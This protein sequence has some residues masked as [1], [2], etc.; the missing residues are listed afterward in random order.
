[1]AILHSYHPTPILFQ[2]GLISIHWYALFIVL[3]ILF[4][5][6]IVLRVS[7]HYGL[8]ADDVYDLAFYLI[9]FST[10][11]ARLYM[12]VLFPSFYLSNP[13]E[14]FKVWNGGLAIHGAIL[15]G[16]LTLYLYT[17]KK[18]Q[19]FWFWGDIIVVALALGQAI[20]RWGNYF[21]QEVYGSPTNLPWGI[22]IDFVNRVSGYTQYEYFHPTFLYESI[23]NFVLFFLLL[24]LH[25]LRIKN[26]ERSG[27]GNQESVIRNKKIAGYRLL[28]TDYSRNGIIALIYLIGYS[29]IRIAMEQFRI[30][31]TQMVFGIR[32]PV[33]VS[34]GVIVTAVFI[35]AR[36]AKRKAFF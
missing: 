33:L 34:A 17:K 4:G 20:G 28:V 9:I 25:Y 2:L 26:K 22:P 32:F 21:N 7:K 24:S 13:L 11:G 29:F 5:L 8:K 36:N 23:L 3:G 12:I 19:N 16:V 15:F 27:I 1:M 31:E 10:L 35:M 14:I 18:K 6:F 30:D